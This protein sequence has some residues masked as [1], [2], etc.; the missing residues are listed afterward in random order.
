MKK[1]RTRRL[2]T[3]RTET[4]R[5]THAVDAATAVSPR[6]PQ[7]AASRLRHH[8]VTWAGVF[9]TTFWVMATLAAAAGAMCWIVK[10]PEVFRAS[11]A[12]DLD[13]LLFLAPRF[14][15]GMLIASFVAVLLPRERVA[16]YV[17]ETAGLKAVSIATAAGGLTPGGPMTSFPLVRALRDAGTGRSALVAYVTSWSNDGV[18]AHPQLGAAT[19]R[20]GAH[21]AAPRLLAAVADRVRH[22]FAPAAERA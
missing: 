11:F 14:G 1:R 20:P 16:R 5:D 6:S 10:G 21:P 18:P 9:G 3:K 12:G 15:A 8:A 19:P 13:L 7:P 17:G 2:R 4:G 22:V